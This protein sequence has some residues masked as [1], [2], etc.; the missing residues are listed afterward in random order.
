LIKKKKEDLVSSLEGSGEG[1]AGCWQ[2]MGISRR[3]MA[4]FHQW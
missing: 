1:K 2:G 4:S 3:R